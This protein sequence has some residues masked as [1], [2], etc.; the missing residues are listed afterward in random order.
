MCCGAFNFTD[1]ELIFNNTSVPLSC[2]NLANP[3]VNMTTCP[4]IVSNAA[5]ANESG[6]IYAEVS[7][8]AH[9]SNIGHLSLLTIDMHVCIPCKGCVS[10]LELL[11]HYTVSVITGVSI[12][13]ALLQVLYLHNVMLFQALTWTCSF[14]CRLLW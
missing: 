14:P 2:C 11:F 4:E 10:H 8:H 1:Y 13:V 7:V 3:L 12:T 9:Q 6:L 5:P